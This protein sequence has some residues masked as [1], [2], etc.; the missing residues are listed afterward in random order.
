VA[1]T[2]ISN[3]TDGICKRFTP[4]ACGASNTGVVYITWS[5][6]TSAEAVAE[7]GSNI[8][9][10]SISSAVLSCC[11]DYQTTPRFEMITMTMVIMTM[12]VL[13]L[14]LVVAVAANAL[15]LVGTIADQYIPVAIANR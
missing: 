7:A 6:G 14:V 8:S 2:A 11:C 13:V 5:F 3:D 4:D 1:G 9:S 12:T 10:C 15:K